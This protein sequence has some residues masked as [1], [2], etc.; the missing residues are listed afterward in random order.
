MI[1]K[2]DSRLIR[3]VS[4]L[5]KYFL[6]MLFGFAVAYVMSV[7]FGASHIVVMLLPIVGDL[8]WRLGILL[9]CLMAIAIIFESLR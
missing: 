9:L 1:T 7:S 4:R 5:L 2:Q 3:L 8:Y 6:L